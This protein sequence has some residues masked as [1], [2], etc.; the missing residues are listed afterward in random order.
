LQRGGVVGNIWI[1]IESFEFPLRGWSDSAVIL[2]GWWVEA[3]LRLTRGE[4]HVETIRFMEGPYAVELIA[5]SK[6]QL[7]VRALDFGAATRERGKGSV[8][9]VDLA[10]DVVS[11]ANGFLRECRRLNVRT[12][13]EDKLGSLVASLEG[14]LALSEE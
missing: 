4:S 9:T 13:D 8:A 3:I 7:Q 6:K 14:E 12:A 10:K 11:A 1:S 2:L 5:D